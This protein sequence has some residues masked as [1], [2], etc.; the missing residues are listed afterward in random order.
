ML[1]LRLHSNGPINLERCNQPLTELDVDRTA[2]RNGTVYRA[3]RIAG[4]PVIIQASNSTDAEVT[5]VITAAEKSPLPDND[6]ITAALRRKFSLDLDLP[7]FYRFVENIPELA[8]LPQKQYGLRPVL[9]DSLLEALWQAVMDQQ[10]NATFASALKRSLLEKYGRCYQF[11]GQALWLMPAPEELAS[12]D[13]HA[14]HPLKFSRNRSSYII[15]LARTFMN[16]PQWEALHGSDDEIVRHL[17]ELRGVGPWTA[18][19]AA[20]VGLGLVDTLPAA[21]IGLLNVVQKV[22][23]LADRPTELNMR[24]IGESWSPWRGLVTF[25]LWHKYEMEE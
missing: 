22:Y 17:C 10:V 25:Y 14:L 16:E 9:K 12:L 15:G 7:G 18:E 13:L 21:D 23:G 8:G 20:M 24:D 2:T 1:T 5:F 6:T 19:Y 4:V 11:D 3:A